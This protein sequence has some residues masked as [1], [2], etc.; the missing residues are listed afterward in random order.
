MRRLVH[1]VEDKLTLL[2]VGAPLRVGPTATL[3]LGIYHRWEP[4]Q[5]Y[6]IVTASGDESGTHDE[7]P[8]M[9]LA[10]YVAPLIRWNHFDLKWARYIRRAALPGYFHATEH[11]DTTAGAAFLPNAAHLLARYISFGYVI[12]LD[13]ESYERYYIGGNRPRKPQL[14]TRYSICFRYLLTLI[15]TRLP[16]ILRRN[17]L[18]INFILES[19]A[20]GSKDAL[21]IIRE[22]Q[23][24]PETQEIA[25]MLSHVPLNFGDKKKVPG[26]Q[27]ADSLSFGALKLAPSKPDMKDLP[28]HISLVEWGNLSAPKPPI[29]HIHLNKEHLSGFKNDILTLVEIRKRFAADI[30][31]KQ[32]ARNS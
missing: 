16:T 3:A 13:K 27:A 19:G 17:D 6:V 31:A 20:D 7:S 26:L 18:E 30:I 8:I 14:D 29:A 2:R 32:N 10:G 12:E 11:W 28:E 24:R 4:G 15:L 21:R 1:W 25:R 5:L 9:I 22:I 23:K